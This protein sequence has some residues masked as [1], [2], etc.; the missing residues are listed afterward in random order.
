MVQIHV[1]AAVT[2]LALGVLVLVLR[3]GT[4]LHAAIGRWWVAMMLLTAVG[5]FW[6]M[7]LWPGHFSPIHLL[8]V[9]TIG[10]LALGLW[11]RRRGNIQG[12]ARTML[13]TFAGLVG[14]GAFTL[15]PGRLMSAVLFGP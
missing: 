2:A 10:S 8:S 1:A 11:Y 4:P 12:H 9:L 14:A 5:S 6:I 15:L 7:R 13:L 3:K